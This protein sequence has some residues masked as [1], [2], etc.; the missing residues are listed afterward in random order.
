MG[1]TKI[2][3]SA[4]LL[5]AISLSFPV[6]S[7]AETRKQEAAKEFRQLKADFENEIS[8]LPYSDYTFTDRYWES[9]SGLKI[10]AMG[11][12]ALPFIM[13]EIK[14]GKSWYTYAAQLITG[15]KMKGPTVD[16]LNR[17]WLDW[18]QE[19]KDDPQWNKFID[20]SSPQQSAPSN[21]NAY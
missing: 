6:F 7:L 12:R 15:I 20:S 19:N 9:E 1:Q 17:E 4:F 3:I 8:Y 18:W 11:K 5:L 21:N 2:K 10:V 16:D 13:E 14:N